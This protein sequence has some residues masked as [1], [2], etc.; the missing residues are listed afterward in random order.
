MNADGFNGTVAIG[1]AVAS[2][3]LMQ[4]RFVDGG[5][6]VVMLVRC[7]VDVLHGIKMNT[8]ASANAKRCSSGPMIRLFRDLNSLPRFLLPR[9]YIEMY[10]LRC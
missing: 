2:P 4:Y 9:V 3:N 7:G 6:S 10:T 5:L 8:V 1:W